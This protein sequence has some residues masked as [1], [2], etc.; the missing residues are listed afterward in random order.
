MISNK[1]FFFYLI[2]YVV[3]YIVIIS[4]VYWSNVECKQKNYKTIPEDKMQN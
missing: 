4:F 1:I 3:N 2:V